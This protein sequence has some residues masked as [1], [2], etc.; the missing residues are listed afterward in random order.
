MEQEVQQKATS[1]LVRNRRHR[2]W[3]K[4]ASGLACIIVFCTVYALIL[5]AI[6]MGKNACGKP[7][8]THTDA[9]YTQV[10]TAQESTCTPESLGLHVHTDA[11]LD[12]NGAYCCG[13]TDCLAHEHDATCYDA[14][15]NLRCKL[16][17]IAA[18]THSDACYAAPH[19]HTDACYTSEG[20]LTCAL[21]TTDASLVCGKTETVTHVHD[22]NCFQTVDVPAD[23]QTL[24]CKL[25]E[26]ENGHTHSARCYGTWELTCG[27]EEHI[28]TLAC[29][30]DL[31]ADVETA[32]D[33]EQTFAQVTLSGVWTEDVLAIAKSQLGYTESTANYTVAPD[34]VTK[35]GYTRYG[36]WYGYPYGDWCAM[37]VSFC[38]HYAGVPAEMFPQEAS[39]PRWVSALEEAGLYAPAG[40]GYLPG[41]GDVV[42][43][44]W[45]G[46]GS[47]DHVGLIN[48]LR[49]DAETGATL[50]GFTTIEG[51]SG[52]CVSVQD[53][54]ADD[55]S[56]LGYGVLSVLSEAETMQADDSAYW[57]YRGNS[58]YWNEAV[59][60]EISVDAIQPNTPYI[61]AGSS[62]LNVLTAAA[63]SDGSAAALATKRPSTKA[64]FSDYVIWYFEPQ[65]GGWRI[66]TDPDNRQ[67]LNLSGVNLTLV[68]EADATVFTV[69]QSTADGYTDRIA[70][71][72]GE[73]YINSYGGDVANCRCWAGWNAMDAGSSLKVMP[74]PTLAENTANRMETAV[75][76]N[77]V[78]NLFD[79]WSSPN[80]AS[81]PDNIDYIDEGINQGHNFKF[82]KNS[83]KDPNLGTMNALESGSTVHSGIVRNTLQDGYPV[84]SGDEIITGGA[85]ESLDYLFDPEK[86]DVA[87]RTA[88]HN[89]GGLLRV[90]EEGYYYFNS[91][92]TM[93]E[94]NSTEN[95]IYVYDKPGVSRSGKTGQFFPM[96]A[97]PQIMTAISDDAIINHYLGLSITTRFI[98]QHGGCS[99]AAGKIPT[100]FSFSGDDDVW[101]FID[102]VLVADLGGAHAS[103]GVDIDFES[104]I[105]TTHASTDTQT[106]L[107]A[108]YAAAGATDK[109]IWSK[110]N[111]NTFADSTTHTLKFFYLERGNWDSN[112]H[113]KYNL[114][115][116]P[117]TAIYKVD[118]YGDSVQGASFA[119]YAADADYHML[120][121][122]GG[123]VV[124]LPEEPQYDENSNIVVGSETIAKALY[125]GTTDAQGELVFVDPDGMPYS[126]SELEDMFGSHFILREIEVPDGYRLVSRDVHLQVWHGENQRILKCD[127]TVDSG[128]RAASTLQITATDTLHLQKAYN[129]DHLVRYCDEQGS[130]NGTLFAVVFKYTGKIDES[131]NAVE[132]DSEKSWTPVYGSDVDGYHLVDMTGKSIAGAALEAA[133][134]A[135]EYGNVIFKLSA[136]ST[137]QLTL[138][139]LPGHITTYYRML[140]EAHKQQARYTVAYYWTP[141]TLEGATENDIYRVYTFAEATEDGKSYSAFDRVFGANIHVPNLI[142]NLLVQKVDENDV[143][144]DGA[145]FA[146]YQVQQQENGDIY[147]RAPDGS[148]VPLGENAVVNS[149][150]TIVTENHG[151]ISPLKT[152]VTRTYDDDVH[153]GTTGF[154]N[155]SDG[156]YIV[157]EVEAPPGYQLNPT[158]VMVLVTEDTIY[159]NAGT[160]DDG[161]TVGR[162]PGYVVSTLDQF[163][164]HGQIDNSLTW[165]YAQMRISKPS[166]SFADVGNEDMIAGFLTENNTSATSTE[167]ANAA[168]TYL[169]Y[170]PVEGEAVFNY[171]P[172]LERSDMA[173]TQ[174]P[175]E[176]R[177]LF[178]TVGWPY[179]EIYQDHE[180]GKN[181][182]SPSA[183]YEDWSN[184]NLTNLFS[185]STYIRVRDIQ[186]TDLQ[187]KKVSAV[188]KDVTLSGAQ[189][190]LYRIGDG[191]TKLYYSRSGETVSWTPVAASALLVETGEDGLSNEKFTKLSDGTYYLEEVKAPAG[192]RLPE[193]PVKLEIVHA[194][195]TIVSPN[196]PNGQT[197]E[198]EPKADN[199]YLYTATI[200]NA[201]GHELPQTGGSGTTQYTAGGALLMACVGIFLLYSKKKRGRKAAASS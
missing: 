22:A 145:R 50:T 158:D 197:V 140:G 172:N 102:G 2:I 19:V 104:G 94:F 29:Y 36:A 17:E 193:K 162:G 157:K 164:S 191:G 40:E 58:I 6:T 106:T 131:G 57:G 39:C 83:Y 82:Y 46:D 150:G 139:N 65:E 114:T 185:R 133:K 163:A 4:F 15:G 148:Y 107:R 79:Y 189:F 169:M 28:H 190:R 188:N 124:A 198:G 9:C 156:Q 127:N 182:K 110:T 62:G 160:E 5:P 132:T 199:T 195:M 135:Q 76:T 10:T 43:F 184:D 144:I 80:G 111:A 101:I 47:A 56:I 93:A 136:S 54:A 86:T 122:K 105:V 35:L 38:L 85:T 98:Q 18:H 42:F 25:T 152:G 55:V 75:T 183:H 113:L 92:E 134:Y 166:T 192:Y 175:T 69:K 109:A 51:N 27:M 103:V 26:G 81:A 33:W 100:T 41:I 16:P 74:A 90:N 78:I 53:Y 118:Q 141:G 48:E 112:L 119:V 171:L 200:P 72:S 64:A 8:H 170:E 108:L 159:A 61:I 146:L 71:Q 77:T 60:T 99:D 31:N 49:Y 20:T 11:C 30:A 142:N 151:T 68:G 179:Y 3:R 123:S 168:R 178:T 128:T 147:Y 23:T 186:E 115:E 153:E 155:L 44:D 13:Y 91:S 187:V 125:K 130:T 70:I 24:T 21:S 176:T 96:N 88:Y 137:M 120:S 177:R 32:S 149:D 121:E 12:D 1:F 67:Y 165:I 37:F 126:L 138:K 87:G 34:G 174:N 196:P 14:D 161:V 181:A 194:V 63:T 116:I 59:L 66:Y 97:A 73:Y 95:C 89:V 129:G 52:N 84:F 45:N 201:T 180:Y 143:R 154:A 7:E 173:G 117:Q 167:A